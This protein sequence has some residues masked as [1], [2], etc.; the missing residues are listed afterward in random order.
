MSAGGRIRLSYGYIFG[1][2]IA[3]GI[4]IVFYEN[5]M[6]THNQG[7]ET[8]FIIDVFVTLDIIINYCTIKTI[9]IYIHQSLST[10]AVTP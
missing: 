6:S 7:N 4:Q 1:K 2:D 8:L 9:T 3:F 10:S 5:I